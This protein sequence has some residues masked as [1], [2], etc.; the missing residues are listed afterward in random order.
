MI[1]VKL[2]KGKALF[3]YFG[4]FYTEEN[5]NS[6]GFS[7]SE[8]ETEQSTEDMKKE[9]LEL[10][11]KLIEELNKNGEVQNVSDLFGES[12][13]WTYFNPII[14][15]IHLPLSLQ[16]KDYVKDEPSRAF[17][18][19][20]ECVYDGS[21]LFIAALCDSDKVPFGVFDIR[22]KIRDILSS[23][24]KITTVPPCL[25][26]DPVILTLKGDSDVPKDLGL[27]MEVTKP[28]ESKTALG[29]LYL[30]VGCEL[31]D[32]YEMCYLAQELGE[33]STKIEEEAYRL[34]MHMTEFLSADW[35]QVL[36][37]RNFINQRRKDMSK[38]LEKVARYQSDTN[39][40]K[41][42]LRDYRMLTVG[43]IWKIIK[44]EDVKFYATPY[45]VLDSD[46]ILKT[47][48][49]VRSELE[50]HSMNRY[51][52]VSAIIGAIVGS[53]FTL[54]FSHI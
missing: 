52:L 51:V 33:Q 2:V 12:P 7:E 15:T 29:E 17:C 36:K 21:N 47:V 25:F 54:L 35:K 38:I 16:K 31:D 37:R 3:V 34:L 23:M 5:E 41:R 32:F 8:K 28:V 43:L 27:L 48:E 44:E 30:Q 9:V 45:A 11:T 18:E 50:T 1:N 26:S 39:L 13:F 22:D 42:K 40:L 46:S 20:F 19:D 14:F 4:C 24:M 6:N 53:L 10:R 49:H